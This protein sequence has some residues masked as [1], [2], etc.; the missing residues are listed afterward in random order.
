TTWVPLVGIPTLVLN[1]P[2]VGI[3]VGANAAGTLPVTDLAWVEIVRA[4]PG[5]VVSGVTPASG[6][7]GQT[8][9]NVVI[10]GSNFVSGAVCNLGSGI[11]VNSCTFNAAAQLTANVT[12]AATATAGPRTV[13]APGAP[14]QHID[15]TYSNSTTLKAD[16]WDFLAKTA[17]NVTR[18]TEQ[19]GALAVDYDQVAHPGVVRMPVGSGELW[20]T[21]NNSQNTLFRT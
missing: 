2:R 4:V 16:G 15:F 19:S 8:L 17:A 21:L 3:Q 20:Q 9:T 5:P 1:N 13:S 10:S 7:Q 11:T 12:I 6:L 14:I 18:N